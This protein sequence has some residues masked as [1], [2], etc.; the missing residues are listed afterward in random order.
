MTSVTASD[1]LNHLFSG[2]PGGNWFE[3]TFIL[4]AALAGRGP[5]PVT[6]SYQLG[7]DQPNWARV[8]EMNQ[9]GYGVYYS[10]TAKRARTKTRSNEA[11]TAWISCLWVDVDLPSEDSFDAAYRA[12]CDILQPATVVI[13][14]GGGLHAI[15]RIK[16][17]PATPE[18][19]KRVKSILRGLAL[20]VGGD[21]HATDLARVLRLPGTI[22]TKPS[23]NGAR[24][25]IIH[26]LPGELT[27]EQFDEYAA[28]EPSSQPA[29]TLPPGARTG[30][31]GWV[32]RYLEHGAPVGERN[33]RLFAAAVEYRANGL[34]MADARRD[35]GARALADGL[36]ERE[37]EATLRSAW[38][39]NGGTPNLSTHIASRVGAWH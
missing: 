26:W 27:L 28:H 12:I 11:N 33:N 36:T 8:A 9:R 15:W 6:W 10:L 32:R 2:I 22:N 23:R 25:E 31:P 13:A 16:P 30:L 17:V 7:Y 19:A 34:T 24:C 38:R 18:T 4:P 5:S 20:Q 1:F 3:L 39:F 35:L 37:V 29:I 21:T 14:S